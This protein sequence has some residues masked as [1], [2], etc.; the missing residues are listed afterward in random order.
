ME[1]DETKGVLVLTVPGATRWRWIGSLVLG[2]VLGLVVFVGSNVLPQ[3][4]LRRPLEGTDYAL[5]GLLQVGLV[6][7]AVWVGLRPL[8][9]GLRDIGWRGRR[10]GRDLTLGLGVALG[11]AL[12]QFA[13]LIPATGG[14]DRSDVA[15][16]AAQIGDSFPGVLGFVVLAWTGGLAE[17]LLFRG[18]IL[19][20]LRNA[21]GASRTGLIVAAGATVLVFALLHG[22]QGWAGV[23]DSG[24]YGGVALTVL[25]IWTSGRL[26][27]CTAAHAGWNSLAAVG[28]YLWY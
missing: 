3:L 7:L 18:H 1:V 11:F 16:N 23:V 17:E 14:A 24:L 15:V 25:F 26:T 6:P 19:T 4:V 20:T 27:A 22:Y 12:L 2:T 21:L 9:I 28:I 8:G 13:V 5:V 10:F